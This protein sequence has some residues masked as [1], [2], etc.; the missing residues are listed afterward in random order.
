MAEQAAKN[1][2]KEA[3]TRL[4]LSIRTLRN[5]VQ[6]A[7]ET[8]PTEQKL[9][10]QLATSR[11]TWESYDKAHFAHLHLLEG[12]EEAAQQE[13]YAE[14]YET[15]QGVLELAEDLLETRRSA[16]AAALEPQAPDVNVQYG[17]ERQNQA[18]TYEGI[19]K[20]V[21]SVETS[22]GPAEEGATDR[23]VCK[24][25]LEELARQLDSAEVNMQ[26]ASGFT[27]EM[28]KLKPD[29]A[30]ENVR[31]E[32]E[33]TQDLTGRMDKL[34]LE[35][36]TRLST[37]ATPE[38]ASGSG[39]SRPGNDTYMYQRRPMPKFDGQKRNYPAFK[40]EWQTG[41]T[42]KFDADF[43]VREIKHNVPSE[44]EPDVKNLTT[45][46]AVWEVL[47]AR[48][49]MVMELTKELI[50]G[51]QCLTFSKQATNNSLKFLEMHNEWVKV[52]NDLEQVG[53]LS[54]PDH[55]P[56][57]CTLAKQLPSEDSKMRYTQLRLLRMADNDRAVARA[58]EG[59]E[60]V[61]VLSPLDIMNEFM[62]SERKIQVS[63]EQLLSPEEVVKA[64][65]VVDRKEDVCFTCGEQGHVARKCPTSTSSARSL[66]TSLDVKPIPCP[67]CKGQH[68]FKNKWGHDAWKTRLSACDEFNAMSVPERADLIE[69]CG[70]CALCLD[71]TSDHKRDN[72]TAKYMGEPFRS[73][74]AFDGGSACGKKHHR[75]LH[76]TTTKYC[77]LL[78]SPAEDVEAG[79]AKTTLKQVQKVP[80][81][82]YAEDAITFFDSGSDV[83]L[84]TAD[85]AARAGWKGYPVELRIQTTGRPSEVK[86]TKCYWVSLIDRDDEAHQILCYEMP[87]ITAPLG[88]VDVS[89]VK[90]IFPHLEDAELV[91][92]PAG[93]VDILIGIQHASLFPWRGD[94]KANMVGNLRLM[95]SKFG[96][97]LLLDGEYP[98][99]QAGNL[100]QSPESLALTRCTV[101][102]VS[103]VVKEPVFTFSECEEMG[104]NQ[105]RRCGACEGCPRCSV[106][107]QTHTRKENAELLLIEDEES[108]QLRKSG[109]LETFNQERVE[110]NFKTCSEYVDKLLTIWWSMWRVF[111]S[112][113]STLLSYY[114]LKVEKSHTNLQVGDVYNLYY[115]NKL[116]S[117]YRLCQVVDILHSDD[118]LEQVSVDPAEVDGQDDD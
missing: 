80:T 118:G 75:L 104:V 83:N 25:Q 61:G 22:L 96:T 71:W 110:E 93:P 113:L 39:R 10:R 41:I 97:G 95:Q 49:G 81:E 116:K 54:V 13:V 85:Y 17:I 84:C 109:Q 32:A 28:I 53:K 31:V 76:G 59:E 115:D 114:K 16:L 68:P 82:G 65:K 70:G 72:C 48:Y 11:T 34:R 44:V 99:I 30:E 98:S 77:N 100:M 2:K 42:G 1:K 14:Q 103:K 58:A 69:K 108:K 107:K 88:L 86:R 105:P 91:R 35:I 111:A 4:L 27:K 101:A 60:P 78:H 20:R 106:D 56:T 102:V 57:L 117:A 90:I 37:F 94:N 66:Y 62:R 18:S 87:T 55:E 74:E 50:S 67:A 15:V 33:M 63:Y 89:E 52:Y 64:K 7:D 45:M 21:A 36:A 29:Q 12:H 9:S 73:C 92:R 51:L 8:R 3:E 5:L 26:T 43:E 19:K 6:G 46:A 112:L 23:R 38:V 24:Q 47:D 40:R 79:D